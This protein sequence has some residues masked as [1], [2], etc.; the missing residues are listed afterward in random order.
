MLQYQLVLRWGCSLLL[1]E[2]RRTLG[3]GRRR[4]MEGGLPFWMNVLQEDFRNWEV[5]ELGKGYM[6]IEW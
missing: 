3:L 2:R 6:K 4:R 1:S 5:E